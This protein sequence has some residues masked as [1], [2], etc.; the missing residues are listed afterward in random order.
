MDRRIEVNLNNSHMIAVDDIEPDIDICLSC[1]EATNSSNLNSCASN[2]SDIIPSL[3]CS[4][5]EKKC[6]AQCKRS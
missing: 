4:K 1:Q 3:G 6:K 5:S 2:A